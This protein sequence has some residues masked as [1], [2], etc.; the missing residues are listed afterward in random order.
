M[1]A[2]VIERAAADARA[3]AQVVEREAHRMVLLVLCL[4]SAEGVIG[5]VLALG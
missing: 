5:G 3:S 2:A 1:G 4:G